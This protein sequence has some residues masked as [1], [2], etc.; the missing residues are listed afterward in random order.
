[1][2]YMGEL[3]RELRAGL[4][5]ASVRLET[6]QSSR[7]LIEMLDASKLH[8]VL[9][10]RTEHTP[11]A[12][13]ADIQIHPLVTQPVFVAISESH[14]LAAH[15]A[16][17]LAA[18]AEFEWVTTP[19]DDG[20]VNTGLHAAWSAT[21]ISPRIRHYTTDATV[22]RSM[23]RAGAVSPT[24][25]T[26]DG[27]RGVAVRPLAGDPLKVQFVIATRTDG[28]LADRTAEVVRCMAR[29]QY[30]LVDDNP[31]YRRWWDCNTWA[32]REI[33]A[34]LAQDFRETA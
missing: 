18:L 34:A 11:L 13:T 17:P 32:H 3:V 7:L 8:V 22:T 21:G 30:S 1:M 24:M 33:D 9:T 6:Q 15:D 20:L 2:S 27:G 12:D 23:V 25:P 29:V 26:F 19:P 14:P 28:P 16:I 31:H 10:A 4:G 5:W